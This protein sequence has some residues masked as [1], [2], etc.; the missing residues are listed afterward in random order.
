MKLRNRTAFP[1]ERLSR[2]QRYIGEEMVEKY[3]AG[4]ISWGQMLRSLILIGGSAAAAAALIAASSDTSPTPPSGGRMAMPEFK[5]QPPTGPL[6]VGAD[7]SSVK[8]EMVSFQNGSS[9]VSGYLA[10]PA[11]PGQYHGV[12]VIHEANSLSEHIKDVARRLAKAGYI[13]LAPD[14]LSRYGISSG[15]PIEK[16]FGLLG[17]AKPEE[18]L[19]DLNASVDY[20][21]GQPEILDKDKLGVVGFC[22]GGGYTLALAANN[23]KIAAAVSYYGVIPQSPTTL[24]NTNAAILGQYGASD[25]RV[26]ASIPEVEKILTSN[27]KIYEKHIY[28]GAGHAFNNDTIANMFNEKAAVEAWQHTLNWFDKYLH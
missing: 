3:E 18:I 6:V 20:L 5:I 13:A 26:N 9:T 22:F 25:A 2:M 15:I 1:L 11:A 4:L 28:E 23:P 12:I 14:L 24:A 17:N 21:A 19:G 10:K 27:G 7:D 16:V 8:G